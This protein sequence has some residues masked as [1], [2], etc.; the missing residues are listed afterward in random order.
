M[1]SLNNASII[2]RSISK[3]EKTFSEF[4]ISVIIVLLRT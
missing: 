3:N 4:C 2:A 1:N